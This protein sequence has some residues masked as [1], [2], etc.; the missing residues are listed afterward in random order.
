MN[1]YIINYKES[2]AKNIAE[3]FFNTIHKTCNKDY[4]KEQ[5]NVWANPNIGY[6][7]WELRLKKSTPY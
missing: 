5:L 1:I 6:K 7:D 4:T 2:F 3:L